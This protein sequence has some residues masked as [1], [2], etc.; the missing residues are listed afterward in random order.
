MGKKEIE[1]NPVT[2]VTTDAIGKPGKRIF[3]LQAF[4][5]DRVVTILVEKVQIQTLAIGMEQFLSEISS[6]YPDLPES[7]SAYDEEKMHIH[8]PVDPVFRAGEIGL[9]YDEK[10]DQVI[11]IIREILND[12]N[13]SEEERMVVR[14]YCSRS[15][16]HALGQWGLEVASRGRPVCPYCGEPMEPEGHF[17]PKKNGHKH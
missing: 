9:A 2:H 14:F 6:R 1:L 12:E 3:Y 7:S 8:P 4:Q 13:V 11:L 10:D 17:C 15:Q 5:D 16:A